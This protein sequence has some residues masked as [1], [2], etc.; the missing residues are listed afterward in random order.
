MEHAIKLLCCL[1]FLAAM[2][3]TATAEDYY[4]KTDHALYAGFYLSVPLGPKARGRSA[5]K[6]R[7]GFAAGPRFD[8][9]ATRYDPTRARTLHARIFDL[10]FSSRG[11]ERFSLAGTTLVGTNRYGGLMA[12]DD[13]EEGG[14]EKKKRS[15]AGTVL[16]VGAI[17]VGAA[18][19]VVIVS[20]CGDRIFDND[21]DKFLDSSDFCGG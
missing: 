19:V 15:P 14:E 8:L 18:L 12:A 13:A 2:P 11:F 4:A 20:A 5:Q 7:F 6:L 9:R 3:A 21:E 16:L 1:A 17:V 10:R